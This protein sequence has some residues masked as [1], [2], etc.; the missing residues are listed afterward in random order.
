MPKEKMAPPLIRQMWRV[1]L[2][3]PPLCFLGGLHVFLLIGCLS[4]MAWACIALVAVIWGLW[5]MSA[6][7]LI[8][9]SIVFGVVLGVYSSFKYMGLKKKYDVPD[10]RDF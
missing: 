3:I 10:W 2:S 5:D 8:V 4:C 9:S 7:Y 6:Q 1:G